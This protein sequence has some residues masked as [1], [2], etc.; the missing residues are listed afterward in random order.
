V[1][2]K[3]RCWGISHISCYWTAAQLG[4]TPGFTFYD[5]CGVITV[6]GQ[7]LVDLY[8]NWV[9]GI[10]GASSIDEATG[11]ITI[12][13]AIESPQGTPDRLYHKPLLNNSLIINN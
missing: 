6:P 13:Y 1:L 11:V 7:N 9:V 2:S 4:G 12:D 8:S 10:A 5:V 3:K